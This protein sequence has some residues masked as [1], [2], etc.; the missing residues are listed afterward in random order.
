MKTVIGDTIHTEE[1]MRDIIHAAEVI[2]DIVH[3][4][5]AKRD[6]VHVHISLILL[7][8]KKYFL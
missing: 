8:N 5:E 3:A 7:K 2:V 6:N 4:A 1:A